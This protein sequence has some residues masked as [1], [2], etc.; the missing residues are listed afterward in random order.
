M[1]RTA[2][3]IVKKEGDNRYGQQW[4]GAGYQITCEVVGEKSDGSTG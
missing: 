2:D 3:L 1:K 4:M